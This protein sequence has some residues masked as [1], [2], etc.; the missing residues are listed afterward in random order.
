MNL[1]RIISVSILSICVFTANAFAAETALPAQSTWKLPVEVSDRNTKVQFD[2]DTTWHVVTG[3]TSNLTGRVFLADPQDPMSVQ[4]EIHFPVKQFDTGWGARN[5]SL[6]DHM[7]ADKFT[8]VVYRVTKLQPTC[9]LEEL[10]RTGECQTLLNGTLSIRDITREAT[11]PAIIKKT[12]AGYEVSGDFTFRWD[13]FNVED[14][15]IIVAKV[16]P[17][18]KVSYTIELPASGE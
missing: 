13:A 18:V 11:I 15:S 10:Q 6:Y 14:P 16:K 12:N 3:K 17:E 9:R 7:A 1:R 4:A 8:E 5:D 2:V